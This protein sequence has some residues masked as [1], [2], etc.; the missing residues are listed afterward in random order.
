MAV[1]ASPTAQ[2]E[3]TASSASEPLLEPGDRLTRDEFERRYARMPHVK[4]AELIEA[5]VYMPSPVRAEKHGEPH[6]RL[7]AWLAVYAAETRGVKGFDNA[8]VRLDI[9]NEPQ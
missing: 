9:D 8:T 5:I 2:P 1:P 4:K 6:I 7:A 3:G